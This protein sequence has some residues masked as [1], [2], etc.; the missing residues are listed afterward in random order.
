MKKLSLLFLI[1][2][3]ITSSAHAQ[4]IKCT[5][6]KTGKVTFSDR[7]CPSSDN[8]EKIDVRPVN[9]FEGSHLRQGA[10][11]SGASEIARN[12]S[13]QFTTINSG[14]RRRICE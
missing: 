3:A 11:Q 10:T 6:P 1:L 5:D 8:G 14:K 12:N 2:A 9:S 4:F 7:L 13:P